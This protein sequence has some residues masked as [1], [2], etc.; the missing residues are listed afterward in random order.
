MA[1][2]SKRLPRAVR[3]QQMLDAA[4]QMFSI[5]GYH[6]TSMDSIAAAAQISKPMLY[7][8]YGSKEELFGACL[9]R[10]LR[11]FVETVRTGIDLKQSPKDLMSNTI[12]AFLRYIDANRASWIVMYAQATSSQAFAHTVREGRE[13]IV[14]LVGRLLRAGTRNPEPGVD[15]DMMA[16]ALVGAGEAIAS[17]VSTGDTDVDEASELMINLFW[18]GLKDAPGGRDEAGADAAG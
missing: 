3:E 18:R 4:V 8:Y 13:R 17:R 15:F 6:E 1:A 10:E 12:R 9:N 11:R 5:N 2:G 16:V 7:L 14:E